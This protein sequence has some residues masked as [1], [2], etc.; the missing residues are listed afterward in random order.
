MYPTPY[1]VGYHTAYSGRL[2][3]APSPIV[4]IHRK[5]NGN[6][7]DE[8]SNGFHLSVASGS[9]TYPAGKYG[10]ALTVPLARRTNCQ[11][12]LTGAVKGTYSIG[13]WFYK[14]DGVL[15]S[16]DYSIFNSAAARLVRL[17]LDPGDGLFTPPQVY[18]QV[19]DKNFAFGLGA[20]ATGFHHVALVVTPTTAKL[21]L[22]GVEVNSLNV[23]TA[24]GTFDASGKVEVFADFG[25]TDQRIDDLVVLP[26][27]AWSASRVAEIVAAAGDYSTL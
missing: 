19:G 5:F 4:A 11:D 25:G 2:R 10:N 14:P 23:S 21:Y 7:N 12:G 17:Q 15:P 13:Y 1:S 20:L 16:T 24:V 8:S 6:L 18:G 9:A 27:T 22:D 3:E 26:D